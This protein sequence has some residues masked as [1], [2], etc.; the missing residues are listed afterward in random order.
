MGHSRGPQ[1]CGPV[2]DF[3]TYTIPIRESAAQSL[4]EPTNRMKNTQIVGTSVPRLE[5]RDKLTGQARYIDDMDLPDML[6]GAAVRSPI[7]RGTIK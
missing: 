2:L 1:L 4:S 6:Y 7:A 3:L 5:G